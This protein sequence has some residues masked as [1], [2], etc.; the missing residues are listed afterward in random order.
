MC[1]KKTRLKRP[2]L[3]DGVEHELPARLGH[4]EEVAVVKLVAVRVVGH[5]VAGDAAACQTGLA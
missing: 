4:R 3:A 2:N 1:E 5:V